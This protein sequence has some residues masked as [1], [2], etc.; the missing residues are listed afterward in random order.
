VLGLHPREGKASAT[1][2]LGGLLVS[3]AALARPKASLGPCLAVP[4]PQHHPALGLHR[5]ES[6]ASAMSRLGYPPS[7]GNPS[8]TCPNMVF[9]IVITVFLNLSMMI[10]IFIL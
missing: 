7:G 6:R 1:M 10:I 8:V 5:R 2:C 4:M 9:F 3:V